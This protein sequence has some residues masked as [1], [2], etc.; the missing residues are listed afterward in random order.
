[1][2]LNAIFPAMLTPRFLMYVCKVF[3]SLEM[4]SSELLFFSTIFFM[5][6]HSASILSRDSKSIAFIIFLAVSWIRS[7]QAFRFFFSSSTCKL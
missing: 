5:F 6:S 3:S 2:I 4:V 7:L 1:M